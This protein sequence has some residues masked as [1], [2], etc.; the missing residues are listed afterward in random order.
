MPG[1][2]NYAIYSN[3]KEPI[4]WEG[5]GL[6]RAVRTVKEINGFKRCHVVDGIAMAKFWAWRSK[7]D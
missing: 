7:Q 2:L 1:Q 3:I 4:A 5:I 6:Y